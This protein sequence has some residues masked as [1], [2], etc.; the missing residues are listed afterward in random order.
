MEVRGRKWCEG[1]ISPRTKIRLGSH[2][3]HLSLELTLRQEQH[4]RAL[5]MCHQSAA[6]H[7]KD[8]T[9]SVYT[10]L[11]VLAQNLNK[12]N[13]RFMSDCVASLDLFSVCILRWIC[14]MSTHGSNGSL[15]EIRSSA[16]GLR[17]F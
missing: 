15:T 4:W 12:R 13:R 1:S 8:C 10:Q 3:I 17:R 6:F 9:K 2:W 7:R 11:G 14:T 5:K 16:Q